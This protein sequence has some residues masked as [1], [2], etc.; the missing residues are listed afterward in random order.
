[1]TFEEEQ[2]LHALLELERAD[3]AK[4]SFLDFCQSVD[5]PGVPATEGAGDG[6]LDPADESYGVVRV[7]PADHHRVIIEHLQAVEAG[8]IKRLMIFLPPGA[9]KSTYA[10]V[11]FPTWYLGRRARRSLICCSYGADLPKK[12]GRR[13]RNIVQSPEFFKIMGHGIGR[14]TKAVDNWMLSNYSEYWSNGILGGLTGHRADGAICDDLIK[15]HEAAD[16]MVQREKIWEAYK[17]D[18]RTRIVPGGFIVMIQTRWHEDDPA[19]RIL[20]DTYAGQSGVVT[21][22][23]GEEW[24]VICMPAKCERDDDPVGRKPGEY[25]WPEWFVPGYFEQ[26]EKTQGER[27][28]SALFQQ[29]PSAEEGSYI[30]SEW[31]RRYDPLRPPQ[32][33]R[34]YGAS[35]YAVT[36]RGGDWT[37]HGIV[38]VDAVDNIYVMDWWRDQTNSGEW[39]EKH[40]DLEKKWRPEQWAQE[41]GQIEKG[42]GPFLNKRRRERRSYSTELVQ[43]SSARD[44]ATRARSIQGRMRQGMVYFPANTEWA[45]DLIARIL[46]FRGIGDEVDDDVDVLSLFGRMLDDMHSGTVPLQH[47]SYGFDSPVTIKQMI[48]KKAEQSRYGVLD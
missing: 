47:P 42:V 39:V 40:I 10:S 19:G 46:R 30:K 5:V 13:C 31:I 2:E 9:S 26:E 14:Q 18:L 6:L 15:G 43:F 3:N 35:D 38:G 16:S 34:F 37:V 1:M 27:N 41:A 33:L 12:F 8:R 48:M 25:L 23:D 29:R 4:A 22:K 45:D 32:W 17:S 11:L 44:K 20:P 28:W 24:N 7:E 36:E 21:S